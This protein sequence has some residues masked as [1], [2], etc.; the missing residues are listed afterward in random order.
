MHLLR[1]FHQLIHHITPPVRQHQ[2]VL[3]L[4][5]DLVVRQLLVLAI[6]RAAGTFFIGLFVLVLDH[7]VEKLQVGHVELA[8]LLEDLL[9]VQM[10]QLG[11][12]FVQVLGNRL[13]RRLDYC[14]PLDTV[15][16]FWQG[17]VVHDQVV[18]HLV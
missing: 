1:L 6:S 13:A 2:R 17:D 8:H 10:P 12:V 7:V 9:D 5:F 14:V 11:Q 18:L 4:F 16:V 15:V 3:K